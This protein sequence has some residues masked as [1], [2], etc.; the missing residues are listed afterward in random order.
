MVAPEAPKNLQ[1]TEPLFYQDPS[2]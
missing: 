2:K 1:K